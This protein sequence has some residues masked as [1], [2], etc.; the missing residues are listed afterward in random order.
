MQMKD[1]QD[2]TPEGAMVCGKV[3]VLPS[4]LPCEPGGL[5]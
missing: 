1:K 4:F 3:R 5:R 2:E